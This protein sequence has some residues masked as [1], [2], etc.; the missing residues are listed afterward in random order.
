MPPRA[1]DF[2]I[3]TDL[4]HWIGGGCS[5]PQ[6]ED[7]NRELR[8]VAYGVIAGLVGSF[9]SVE[10]SGGR[11]RH[12]PATYGVGAVLGWVLITPLVA[13]QLS[14]VATPIIPGSVP[15]CGTSDNPCIAP[16]PLVV[17]IDE[18]IF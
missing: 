3:P 12:S 7:L 4:V 1:C 15:S 6:C 16:A 18:A 13:A 9:L 10:L 11:I 5:V 14:K 2:R 8:S 17:G